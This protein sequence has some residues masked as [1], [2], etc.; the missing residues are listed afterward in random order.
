MVPSIPLW[1]IYAAAPATSSSVVTQVSGGALVDIIGFNCNW[2]KVVY[3][4]QNGTGYIRSDLVTLTEKPSCNSG[5]VCSTAGVPTAAT[6]TSTATT[7]TTSSAPAAS[8]AAPAV[9]NTSTAQ[10]IVEFGEKT[11]WL[12]LRMGRNLSFRL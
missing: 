9:S 1:S 10:Q 6:A 7:T 3:N 4:G 11:R 5:T 12:S 2:Y 8:A